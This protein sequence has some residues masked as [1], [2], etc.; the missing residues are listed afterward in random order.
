[1]TSGSEE[2]PPPSSVTP[3]ALPDAVDVV[4]IGAGIIGASC[5]FHLAQRGVRVAVLDTYE[6]AAMGSSGRSF[7]SLRTQ[8]MDPTN[9]ALSW[10]GIQVYRDFAEVHGVDVGYAPT[11]YLLLVPEQ[12]WDK[13]LE[14][15]ALQRSM[16]ISVD[17]LSPA[18]AQQYTPFTTDGLGGC[19][20]G[21]ADGVVDPHLVTTTYLSM[22]RALGATVHF[23]HRITTIDRQDDGWHLDTAHGAIRATTVV[24]AAGGWAGEVAELAGLSVPVQHYRRM[25]F[26][27]AADEAAPLLP[28]T[29]DVA[30]GFYLRSEGARLLMGY[31]NP[32]ESPGYTTSMEWQWLETALETGVKRFPW[33]EDV[34]IDQTASWAGT[35]EIT[36]DHRPF[37]GAMTDQPAWVNACGFS[38]H[39]VMQAPT[40]GHVIAEEVIDGRAHSIN[41]DSLR[42]DRLSRSD[43]EVNALVF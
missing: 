21:H 34:P 17:V 36:P 15:V 8:W 3:R 30:T 27:S 18:D 2:S 7:A 1:M 40:V 25:I 38:G 42:I 4:V 9:I 41:I 33:L 10:G 19:T 29:I 37:L 22:A 11:G 24:N 23:R 6:A 35:Y 16:G 13:Q 28:M 32:D 12:Q 31:A 5:A 14:A 39:G 26:A 43:L 20:W